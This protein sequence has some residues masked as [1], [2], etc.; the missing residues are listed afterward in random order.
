MKNL[1]IMRHAK[2]DWGS[3]SQTDFDRPLNERGLKSAPL[4]GKELARRN[5][6]PGLIISSPA[7]R[8]KTTAKL[9]AESCGYN[10]NIRFEQEF[11]FG[12]IDEILNII[13]AVGN[14]YDTIMTVGHN[15]TS[16]SLIYRLLK[17]HRHQQMPTAAVASIN[18]NID[19]WNQ[20]K[21]NSGEL[22][23]L[24]IPRELA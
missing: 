4:M 22:E 19:E 10:Q 7:N 5:K 6:I 2:S 16:E 8:A 12:S 1:L 11:Y 15:P 23:W 17:E 14:E 24:I 21:P 3:D 9:A 18:F 13:M 20:L